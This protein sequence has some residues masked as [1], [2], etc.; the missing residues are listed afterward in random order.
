M[1]HLEAQPIF[2]ETETHAEH[3]TELAINCKNQLWSM[4]QVIIAGNHTLHETCRH[5]TVEIEALASTG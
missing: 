3:S 1:A 2:T 5:P 4:E